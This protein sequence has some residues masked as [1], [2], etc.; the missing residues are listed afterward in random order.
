MKYLKICPT[1]KNEFKGRKNKVYCSIP[2]KSHHNNKK[3]SKLRN[4]LIDNEIMTRN[5]Q[6]LKDL[7][8]NSNGENQFEVTELIQK[9]FHFIA[10]FRRM[11]TPRNGYEY[12]VIHSYGFRILNRNNQQYVYVNRTDELDNF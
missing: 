10:P 3:A 5:Y 6:I 9:G 11:K 12:L 7:Y 4:E 8:E 2:C 1:C